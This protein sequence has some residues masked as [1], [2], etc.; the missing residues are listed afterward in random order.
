MNLHQID[1]QPRDYL[2]FLGL[3]FDI[4]SQLNAIHEHLARN[5]KEAADHQETIR[6]AGEEANQ[7]QDEA[8][9]YVV[10]RWVDL[11]HESTYQAAA[12]SMAAVGMLAPFAE[13]VFHR[14]FMG[15]GQKFYRMNDE[16]ARW[17]AADEIRWDCHYFLSDGKAQKDL[18]RGIMQ[19]AQAVRIAD[20][21][22]TDARAVLEALFG[23]RNQMFHHG[24]EWPASERIR[25][26]KRIKEQH[27]PEDW[28]ESSTD[29]DQPW[30]FYMSDAFIRC[31]FDTLNRVPEVFGEVVRQR[32][33]AGEV[34]ASEDSTTKAAQGGEVGHG[35]NDAG[36][37]LKAGA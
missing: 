12:H 23:Y 6:K 25:F 18:V 27:W 21:L 3:G 36:R 22:P 30:I 34:P 29:D 5:K 14:C 2:H 28:F 10:D 11:V 1:L 31:C 4:E 15:L 8:S 35:G 33:E 20:R 16:H 9:E 32:L 19:L 26:A 24:F 37:D 17:R 7:L 13:T